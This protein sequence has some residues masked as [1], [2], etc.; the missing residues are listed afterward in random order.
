MRPTRYSLRTADFLQRVVGRKCLRQLRGARSTALIG[1]DECELRRGSGR[2]LI[3]SPQA[4]AMCYGFW[5]QAVFD[6]PAMD[7]LIGFG[8][9][10]PRLRVRRLCSLY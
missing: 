9:G 6:W 2:G 3:V 5:G 4:G 10:I 1:V 7:A 8:D